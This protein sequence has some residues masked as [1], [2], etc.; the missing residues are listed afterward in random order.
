MPIQLK[1][2]K[3]IE[4]AALPGVAFTVRRLAQIRRAEMEL[5][6]IGPRSEIAKLVREYKSIMG[7][8]GT[9]DLTTQEGR[10]VRLG[11]LSSDEVI[12]IA[13]IDQRV[14]LI[15]DQS[16]KPASIRTALVSIEELTDEDG[17]PVD[18]AD[19]LLAAAT[20]ELDGLME[21][22]YRAC[23]AAG[24]L[25]AEETKNLPSPITGT[26]PATGSATVTA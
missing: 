4:S 10:T 2:K 16:L 21:E 15:I 9:R 14:A 24:G 12:K 22:I 23:E 18:T 20:P 19:K 26:E 5:S 7:D 13:G 25:D 11:E 6:T 1:S 17:K 3:R 8:D